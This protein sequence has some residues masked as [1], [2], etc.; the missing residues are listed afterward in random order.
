MEQFLLKAKELNKS[1]ITKKSTGLLSSEK[2]QV[3]AL[4]SFDLE[5]AKPLIYGLLGGN[6]AGKTTLIKMCLGLIEPTS[7]H[8]EIL[9]FN[10]YNKDKQFLSQVGLVSGQKQNLDED[11]SGIDNLKL[12]GLLYNLDKKTIDIRIKELTNIFKITQKLD[13]PIRQLSL[14][15][16][17]KFEI[18][19]SILHKPKILFLDEPTIGLDF[20]TQNTLR[21]TL[22]E[23]NQKENITILI[24]SHYMKDITTL[25]HKVAILEDGIKVFDGTIEQLQKQQNNQGYIRSVLEELQ[26][27]K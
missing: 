20:D 17:M 11:L 8:L 9:G 26:N 25:C 19:S 12:S 7:G 3:A 27:Q 18:I 16:R 5:I 15:Q 23:L 6:G 13:T 4:K 22:K 1:F 21:K 14:G 24:T 2:S 10:P